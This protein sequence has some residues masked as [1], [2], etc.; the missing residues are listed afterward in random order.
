MSQDFKLELPLGY[1]PMIG[2]A[3]PM[4]PV[5]AAIMGRPEV[6]N[7][8]L[9]NIASGFYE[10]T[11]EYVNIDGARGRFDLKET[12]AGR[13]ESTHRLT[14]GQTL[15]MMYVKDNRLVIRLSKV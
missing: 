4:P 13:V 10:V 8:S 6:L 11:I 9:R 1:H 7:F 12:V 5:L 15:E 14:Y 3:N 2:R